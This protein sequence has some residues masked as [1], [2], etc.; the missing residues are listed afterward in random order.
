MHRLYELKDKLLTE[1][2]NQSEKTLS[3]SNIE[4]VDVLA[5]ALKNLC[6]VIESKENEYS[7]RSGSYRGGYNY[8]GI[9]D[10]NYDGTFSGSY[11]NNSYA[12]GEGSNMSHGSMVGHT[13]NGY[14]RGNSVDDIVRE[15]RNMADTLPADKQEEAKR[16]IMKM[17]QL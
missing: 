1:L 3:P 8:N 11:G 5:H 6:K 7:G 16:L 12:R 2:M 14:S 13:Y 10:G 17:E 4:Y 15:F 9:Y